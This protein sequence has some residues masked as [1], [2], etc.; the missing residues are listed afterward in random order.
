MIFAASRR[1]GSRVPK[2]IWEKDGVKLSAGFIVS[3]NRSE[4]DAVMAELKRRISRQ[5]VNFRGLCPT[6]SCGRMY[7]TLFCSARSEPLNAEVPAGD[8]NRT[9]EK[10]HAAEMQRQEPPICAGSDASH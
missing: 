1:L 8:G 6:G 3:R 9:R 7:S 5:I 2:L 10:Q 4:T